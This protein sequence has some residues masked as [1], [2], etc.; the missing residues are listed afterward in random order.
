MFVIVFYLFKNIVWC[1]TMNAI[2]P[3]DLKQT[4]W[5][6]L[7]RVEPASQ[8]LLIITQ[9]HLCLFLSKIYGFVSA[10]IQ[11]FMDVD[12][13]FFIFILFIVCFA[14]QTFYLF[15]FLKMHVTFLIIK[16]QSVQVIYLGRQIILFHFHS[17]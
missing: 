11:F 13:Y 16:L 10:F 14:K 6:V 12:V 4:I 5:V 15:K 1:L 3:F 8:K 17:F 9:P 2:S 7:T